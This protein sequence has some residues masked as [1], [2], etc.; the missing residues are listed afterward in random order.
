MG[1]KSGMRT[2]QGSITTKA[3]LSSRFLEGFL[4]QTDIIH[5]ITVTFQ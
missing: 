1:K 4:S 5:E 2:P 3:S